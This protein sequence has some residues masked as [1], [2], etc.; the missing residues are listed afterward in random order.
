MFHDALAQVSTTTTGKT[1]P[2]ATHVLAVD[3]DPSVRQMVADYLGDNEIQVTALSSGREIAGVMAQD[4]IDL[5]ILDLKLPGED[6]MEIA[7]RIRADSNVPIIM[8]T[9]RKEEA[10]RVMAL[11]LGADDYLTKPFSPRELL[12]RIRA[13]LRRSRSHETVADGLAKIRAYRFAGWE[14]NVRV[15]RLKSPQGEVI[16]L[17]NAEFNLLAAFLASP[18]RVLTREQ[19]LGMSHLHNDE[20]YDRA[21]D[22]Q[23]GRLRKKLEEHSAGEE[24]IRTERG[25]GYV[26]TVPVEVVR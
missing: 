7:R 25:A 19:L 20:V 14:L 12:A 26:L 5:V 11:E 15:R 18:Q 1:P 9:G 24:L 17:R 21:V 13:L 10:D 3:D 2:A 8:L 4:M 16:A 22:T 23:V 6:G